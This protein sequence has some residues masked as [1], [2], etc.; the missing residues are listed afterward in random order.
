MAKRH[1][2]NN[3][4]SNILHYPN[5]KDLARFLDDCRAAAS[6]LLRIPT[7][8]HHDASLNGHMGRI[9]RT[10]P[11]IGLGIG[12]VGAIVFQLVGAIGLPPS[13]A[14][15]ATLAVW[16]I[17]TGVLHEDGLAD[18]ADALAAPGGGAT[19]AARRK[20]RI[21]ILHAGPTIGVAGASALILVIGG[22][23]L[24]LGHIP[25]SN[26]G[27]SIIAAAVL[28]RTAIVI[29]AAT[30]API[31]SSELAKNGGA[32]NRYQAG[33]AA[34]FGFGIALIILGLAATVQAIIAIVATVAAW[35]MICRSCFGGY[36][37]DLC[38]AIQQITQ[39]TV[40]ASLAIGH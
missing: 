15:V 40:I 22:Q 8:R 23:I 3:P 5:R 34:L 37:G 19:R 30:L 35:R 11:L 27:A 6:F 16:M 10:F 38:G 18:S 28:S 33:F 1:S 39:V 21:A 36:N 29:F 13:V 12:I 24:L 2:K 31:A 26:A 17:I 32:P 25:P 9:M 14:A 7:I 4:F 20:K